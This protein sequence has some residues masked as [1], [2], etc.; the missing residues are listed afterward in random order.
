MAGYFASMK[1][2]GP[3]VLICTVLISGPLAAQNSG[4][5]GIITGNVVE[6]G[7][8]K[9]VAGATVA[10]LCPAEPGKGRSTSTNGNGEFTLS[11][12]EM[13]V[14]QLRIS[15][16]GFNTLSI[17]S[18]RLRPERN[19]FNL[20]DL[21]LAPKSTEMVAAV[22]YAEKPLV[23]SKGGNLTFNAAESP[24]S[25]GSSANELLKNVP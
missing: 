12:L 14:Y 15:S 3:L 8:G 5:G 7:T 21:K 1:L 16:V 13:G 20:N 9:A 23:Q 22:V 6:E 25:A 4:N 18:I 17:D 11:G 2:T 24:L 10:L 19:D